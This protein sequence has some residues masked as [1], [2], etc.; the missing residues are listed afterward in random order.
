MS[1]Y[2]PSKLFA[3]AIGLN[4]SRD[5]LYLSD[6]PQFSKLR[7]FRK[8]FE[9]YKHNNLHLA[10]KYGWIFNYGHMFLKAHSFL[11]A[12]LSEN[13]PLLR[14][15]NIRAYFRARWT[16]LLIYTIDVFM[17]RIHKNELSQFVYHSSSDKGQQT[18]TRHNSVFDTRHG[19]TNA[20]LEENARMSPFNSRR[21]KSLQLN[22][23]Q[24]ANS[25]QQPI[26]AWSHI[27]EH[28][29][30]AESTTSRS[31]P[32]SPSN[33]PTSSR[34]RANI[35]RAQSL[36]LVS[37]DDGENKYDG[38]SRN[39]EEISLFTLICDLV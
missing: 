25:S 18:P 35:Q 29:S 4:V 22:S 26:N 6:N 24:N 28:H 13:C 2:N 19:Q 27:K 9:G 36:E 8:R 3:R 21:H 11:R 31:L 23:S 16:L 20:G 17:K 7:V 12:T 34:K 15:S 30:D 10:W 37:S 32:G 38:R 39:G 5:W 14:T 33:S 1:H